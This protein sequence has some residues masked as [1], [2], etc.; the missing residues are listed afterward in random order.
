[1]SQKFDN[2]LANLKAE[3]EQKLKEADDKL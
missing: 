3:Y 2:D 1:L